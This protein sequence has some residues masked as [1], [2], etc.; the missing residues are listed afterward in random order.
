[1]SDRPVNPTGS[2]CKPLLCRASGSFIH[3]VADCPDSWENLP[4]LHVTE[5][6]RTTEGVVLFTGNVEDSLK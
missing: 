3:L 1:M 4:R 2:D 5:D 6:N